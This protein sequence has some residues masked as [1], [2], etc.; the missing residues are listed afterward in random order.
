[1]I[2]VVKMLDDIFKEYILK[3]ID[4]LFYVERNLKGIS[5]ID[6]YEVVLYNDNFEIYNNKHSNQRYL[7]NKKPKSFYTPCEYTSIKSDIISQ[8]LKY[9]TFVSS[10]FN[11]FLG[12]LDSSTELSEEDLFLLS[13][14]HDNLSFDN[15]YFNKIVTDITGHDWAIPRSF[16]EEI[17]YFK[18]VIGYYNG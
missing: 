6:G 11:M 4:D 10:G 17:K 15:F 14:T 3:L 13:L 7:F 2:K 18:S 8:K 16:F 5:K 12:V 1:M 9:N